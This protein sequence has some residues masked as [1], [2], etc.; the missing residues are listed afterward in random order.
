MPVASSKRDKK[1]MSLIGKKNDNDK[2][3]LYKRAAQMRKAAREPEQGAKHR[4][5]WEGFDD[6]EADDRP[7]VPTE[8][9]TPSGRFA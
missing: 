5:D 2:R 8:A 6:W 4:P 9:K 3:R 1:R 7:E